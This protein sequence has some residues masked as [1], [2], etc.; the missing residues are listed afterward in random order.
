VHA[1]ALAIQHQRRPFSTGSHP[2]IGVDENAT[3]MASSTTAAGGGDAIGN[4]GEA[5]NPGIGENGSNSGAWNMPENDAKFARRRYGDGGLRSFGYFRHQLL[6]IWMEVLLL[7]L[8]FFMA[9]CCFLLHS[10][11]QALHR[12]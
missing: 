6:F 7:L 9:I 1:T 11:M 10:H 3:T 12:V 8:L 2:L 4:P 5:S